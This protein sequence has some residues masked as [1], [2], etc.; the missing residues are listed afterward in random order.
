MKQKKGRKQL[1]KKVSS[2]DI[3]QLL[4]NFNKLYTF[5]NNL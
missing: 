3:S 5:N 1:K 4:E 2:L